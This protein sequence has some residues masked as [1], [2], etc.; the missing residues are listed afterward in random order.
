MA[1]RTSGLTLHLERILPAP[2][3]R[4]FAACVEPAKLAADPDDQETV[5]TLTFRAVGDGTALV[6]DQRPFV[7]EARHELHEDSWTE[8]LA[9]LE[10]HLARSA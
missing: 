10:R 5:V 4:V 8:G 6:L 7:T 3:E 9:R 1:P 2:P